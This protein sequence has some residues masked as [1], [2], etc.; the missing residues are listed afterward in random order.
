MKDLKDS[1]HVVQLCSRIFDIKTYYRSFL[2]GDVYSMKPFKRS[3]LNDGG[4][5]T[6]YRVN[7]SNTKVHLKD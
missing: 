3:A 1:R 4:R 6:M 2:D 5:K 7:A